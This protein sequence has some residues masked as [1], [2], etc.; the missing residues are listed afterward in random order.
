[1]SDF[2][3]FELSN[4]AYAPADTGF[5]TVQSTALGRRADIALYGAASAPPGSPVII[6]LHGVYGSHWA[7]LFSGGVHQVYERLRREGLGAFVLAMPSDGLQGDGSGYF[8]RQCGR[9]EAWIADEVPA[10]VA[11]AVPAV[12]AQSRHYISGLS[13]GGYGAIRI[14]A[15][16]PQR[17]AGIS[18][19]SPITSLA[20][21]ALFTNER[22]D[23]DLIDP[24]IETDLAALLPSRAG[25]LP[26]FRFDCGLDDPLLPAVRRLHE[27]LAAA[28]V[29]HG[30]AEPAGGH[31]WP[32]WHRHIAETLT[33]FD[34]IERELGHAAAKL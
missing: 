24:A 15:M 22:F 11:R 4:P 3:T 7:W 12:T 9:F 32:Y 31:D 34:R 14:G 6:L 28:G 29:D 26:R 17:F 16:H 19:H 30:Y 2:R 21:F 13:M 1:M 8:D 27:V 10:A 18:G 5:I 23:D 33:F 25:V 20:D